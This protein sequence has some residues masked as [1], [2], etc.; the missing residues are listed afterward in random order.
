[1]SL[2][3]LDDVFHNLG[4]EDHRQPAPAPPRNCPTG[5]TSLPPLSG[6]TLPLAP[7]THLP[8]MGSQPFPKMAAPAPDFMEAHQGL[9]LP[10]TEPP[11]SSADGPV[12]A[13]PSVCSDPDCEGHRCEGNGAYEHQPYDGEESQDEDSCS[14]HSSSTSTSTNQ[15]EGKY[16][17]CCYCE[18]FGH[19]GPPAAPTS[20]NYAEMREKL[21][22]RLTKRK[23][24][25]PKREEQQPVIERDGGVED[26][27]RVEDLLQFIN[28]ADNKP[29]S[30]SKA[31]KRARHKLKKMEEKARLE[32]EARER[33][34]QQM[35]EEQQRRQRQEEEEAALQKE[36]L[37]LQELQQ[38]RAAKKKKK[39]KAKE[40]TA[41]TQNNPQPLKQT[42]QN[43]LDNLQ[44]GKSQSLLQTLIR[45]PEQ[46]EP[47][48][49][50]LPRPNTQHSPKHSSERGF[51]TETNI[52]SCQ[53]VLHNGTP[54]SQLEVNSKV[55]AKQSAK[56]ATCVAAVK[57][58][59]ELPKSSDVAAKLANG[60]APTSTPDTKATRIRPA[61][62][63]LAPLPTTEP[64]R[65]DRCNIRSASGK[66]QQQLQQPLS[67]IKEDRRSPP[68]SNPSPSPPPAFQPEQTQQNGKPP[69][70]ESP[71]PKGKT[72]KNKKKKVDKM[73]TSIDDVF[74]PKDIDLDSTEMDET[75]REVEYFKRFCLD[76]ARQTRQR[77]SINWSNFSLKK[78]TFA[79]H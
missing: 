5:L 62:A 52:P 33:E 10:P 57:K 32:A 64:R 14:E 48:F 20:R 54:T 9:C 46:K 42:A 53:A 75:E 12:S 49:D 22:L 73:N 43:V 58:A 19:G 3:A 15:K 17:D 36:L 76:S 50:P 40:N 55:K 45:L 24:E 21:R 30:S 66:R 25:Q 71:Q 63:A 7:T 56:V 28:S 78:A 60:S 27:R 26:H 47:R 74:L 6:P 18:F 59:P 29:A 67:H 44:N 65:E 13:P 77:L 23:E 70:A 8:T 34:E 68:V 31:A 11:A 16:C 4:K 61:E 38:H 41:P 72:K 2:S 39:E 1:M 51:S 35:L 37:R 79:A 69:S